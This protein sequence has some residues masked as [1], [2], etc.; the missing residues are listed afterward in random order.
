MFSLIE[1]YWYRA[2]YELP[3][4]LGQ[5]VDIVIEQYNGCR[6]NPVRPNVTGQRK[7]EFGKRA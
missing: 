7:I 2:D 5:L 1:K 6:E 4:N 3:M